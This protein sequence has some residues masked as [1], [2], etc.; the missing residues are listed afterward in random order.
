MGKGL[1]YS[2]S[3]GIPT[4]VPIIKKTLIIDHLIPSLTVT[5]SNGN[6]GVLI[7]KFEEG[8]ILFLGAISNISFIG[9]IT[10]DLVDTWSGAYG[11]GT[12]I[13]TTGLGGDTINIIND[14][15]FGPAVAEIVPE[16]RGESVLGS[17]T[18]DNTDNDLGIYLNLRVTGVDQVD[19]TTV[20]IRAKG[21]LYLLY[22]V[23]GDD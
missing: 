6:G 21:R 11:M 8:N 13:S 3:R 5:T 7:G 15:T 22:S 20:Q 10:G 4:V 1:P 14:S 17:T 16:I 18:Y 19:D 9:P 12:L 2:R 23:L